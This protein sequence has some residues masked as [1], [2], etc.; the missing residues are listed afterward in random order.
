MKI[1]HPRFADLPRLR[2]LWQA[3]FGDSDA[4]LD[5]F[6][7]TAFSPDHCL[8][9]R[10][11]QQIVA[12]AYWMDCSFSGQ[13]AAYVYAVVTAPVHRG[14]GHCRRLMDAIHRQLSDDGYCGSLLVP[15]EDG[16]RQMYAT[17][18]YRDFGGIAEASY[19]AGDTAC[20]MRSL[21]PQELS[22]LRR[23]YL[24]QG[25]VVQEGKSLSLLAG[26]ADFYAGENHLLTV[27]REGNRILECLGDPNN[28]PPSLAA[29]GI[30]QAAVRLPGNQPFAMYRPLK[31]IPPPTYFAFAF[32]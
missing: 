28:I 12:A 32:D 10:L 4:F 13:T 21:D 29:L 18:G 25:G 27:S 23:Q 30:P 15:A 5:L 20:Q 19:T 31:Q 2:Q 7:S 8:C 26:L 16:L 14:Q 11:D 24:P 22:I 9:V 1:D 6:F 17:M 3:V